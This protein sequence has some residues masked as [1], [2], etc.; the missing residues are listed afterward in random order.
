MTIKGARDIEKWMV[1]LVTFIMTVGLLLTTSKAWA[2]YTDN[3]NGTVTDTATGLVWQQQDDG[4]PRTW[5]EAVRYCEDLDLASVNDWRLPDAMEL[6][7]ITDNTHTFPAINSTAFPGTSSSGYWSHTSTN[8][9]DGSNAWDVTFDYG[10]VENSFKTENYYARCVRGEQDI[11]VVAPGASSETSTGVIHYGIPLGNT[12]VST[13]S[14]SP[15]GATEVWS[16]TNNAADYA[17]LTFNKDVNGTITVS[18]PLSYYDGD[19]D[20]NISGTPTG[21]A[22][23]N[24]TSV[25]ITMSGTLHGSNGDSAQC[26]VVINGTFNNGQATVSGSVNCPSAG[27]S[28][29]SSSTIH[30]VRTNGSGITPPLTTTTITV[31]GPPIIGTATKGNASATVTF[32]APTSNGGS[33]ITKYT[34]TSNPGSKTATGTGSPITVTGLTNGKAYTFTVKATNAKGTGPASAQ[35]NS[36]IPSTATTITV[37]GPPIIGT[38]T[39]GDASATVTFTAPTSDGGSAITKYTVTSSPGSKTA[40]GTGSPISVTGLTNGKTY[41]FTVKATNAKGTGAASAQSNSVIPGAA[42]SMNGTYAYQATNPTL[43]GN[44]TAIYQVLGCSSPATCQIIPA[45]GEM[46]VTQTNSAIKVSVSNEQMVS[47]GLPAIQFTGTRK[48]NTFAATKQITQQQ[49][50][51]K[52]TAKV[53]MSASN[54]TDNAFSG[55]YQGDVALSGSCGG[56]SLNCTVQSDYNATK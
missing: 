50:G 48:G 10:I 53:T 12:K 23:V 15:S 38:A 7:S 41:T 35:S 43:N 1:W 45:S 4:T 16:F 18:G 42:S 29:H 26:N 54:I 11:N 2:T 56:Y 20:V 55:N 39:R 37:P 6:A 36:V 21:S 49:N 46:D 52:A 13:S 27:Y 17:T 24:S 33:A 8:P 47:L 22:T 51:C 25:N 32:T 31:P 30:G 3:G 19:Y 40:T 9:F 14:S 44:C 28:N 5:E 34:V